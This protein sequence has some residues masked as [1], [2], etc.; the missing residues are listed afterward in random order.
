MKLETRRTRNSHKLIQTIVKDFNKPTKCQ[1]R[2]NSQDC[3]RDPQKSQKTTRPTKR[4]NKAKQ[5]EI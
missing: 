4:E 3:Q 2:K 5:F 1:E